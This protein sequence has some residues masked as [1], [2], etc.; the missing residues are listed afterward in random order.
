MDLDV[1]IENISFLDVEVP[2]RENVQNIFSRM[3]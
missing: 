1:D 2:S 3:V